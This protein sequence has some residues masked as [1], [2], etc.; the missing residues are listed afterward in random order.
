MIIGSPGAG[1]STLAREVARR[2]GLPLHHLDQLYWKPG[3]VEPDRQEW[4]DAVARLAS[5]PR[6]IIEGNYGGTLPLRLA[7]ADTVIDLALPGWLCLTR[8]LRRSL[9][10]WGQVRPHMGAGCPERPNW[11]FFSY[12][13]TFPWRG[14]RRIAEKMKGFGGRYIGLRSRA[15]VARFSDCVAQS[16]RGGLTR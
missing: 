4:A 10:T 16:N 14:R 1:K 7:R 5:E 15:E 11:E 8:V 6:W 12:T 13:A 9:A 3:W 2:T